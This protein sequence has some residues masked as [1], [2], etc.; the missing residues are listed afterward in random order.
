MLRQC[1]LFVKINRKANRLYSLVLLMMLFLFNGCSATHR[2]D[3]TFNDT[4]GKTFNISGKIALSE[5]VETDSARKS[6][7]RISDFSYFIVSA[8][9]VSAH[10]DKDGNFTLKGVAFSNNL[11]LKAQANKIALLCRVTPDEICYSDLSS[12]EIN[13]NTTA[14][15]LVYQQGLLLKK[16]LTP[17]D[18]RAREYQEG[19][20][21][22]VT[23]IKLALQ[24][25]KESIAKTELEITAVTT[26]AKNVASACVERDN[27]LK[28][29]NSVIHNAF[30]RKDL[31]LL[32]L[33]LSP[34]FGN[35]WDSS[36]NWNDAIT[37][38]DILFSKYNI[39]GF[40]WKILDSEFL[41]D[42][43]ARIRTKVYALIKDNNDEIVSNTTWTFDA[44]WRLEG[45]MW[46]LFR[47]M[48]YKPTHPTQV[49]ADSRW[50]EIAQVFVELQKAVNQEDVT[51]ISNRVSDV[52]RN[53]FDGNSTKN[54]L[55]LTATSRFNRM[56]VKVSEYS[57]DSIEFTAPDEAKVT[58]HGRIKVINIIAGIDIDSGEVQ[59]KIT[60]HKENGIWKVY[61]D[62]P[63]KFSHPRTLQ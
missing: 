31:D 40:T 51:T 46:K 10:S 52:F 27:V 34:S 60:F 63:Y 48:P 23:A 16:N 26:A 29:A 56:D 42:N 5:F 24:L 13:I 36:S 25:P 50:G 12:L 54:D 28:D 44:L 30:L 58:C 33:Y 49:D 47:N 55:I 43:K 22:I 53:E 32:K 3:L 18:I 7:G 4:T 35:D 1:R 20:A 2:G 38:F 17:A 62:L 19:L 37:C 6:I 61:R 15:A 8:G 11:V 39:H 41:A 9:N 57:I 21:S 45:S 59:A 14:E